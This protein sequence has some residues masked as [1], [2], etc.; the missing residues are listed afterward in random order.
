MN[1]FLKQFGLPESLHSLTSNTDV[2]DQVWSKIEEFQTKGSSNNLAQGIAG[3]ESLKQVNTDVIVACT[4]TLDG[5]E[6]E[7][8]AYRT[9]YG[10]KFARPA[11]A[12]VNE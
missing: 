1:G 6:Q 7:D 12:T 9:Q 5:E 2:P 10:S 8:T 3:A 11:S 4:A